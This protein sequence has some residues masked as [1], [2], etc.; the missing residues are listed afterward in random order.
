[1]GEAAPSYSPESQS[2]IPKVSLAATLTQ[3]H[4]PDTRKQW[5]DAGLM[6]GATQQGRVGSG[7]RVSGIRLKQVLIL[8]LPSNQPPDPRQVTYPL[9]WDVG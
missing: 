9:L 5:Q 4:R 7:E 1:M 6:P 8:D 2:Q 3:D